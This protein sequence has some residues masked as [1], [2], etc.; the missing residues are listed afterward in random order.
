MKDIEDTL[1]AN[2]YY[3]QQFLCKKSQIETSMFVK[4][5]GL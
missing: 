4:R 2:I 1:S 5:S 3:F